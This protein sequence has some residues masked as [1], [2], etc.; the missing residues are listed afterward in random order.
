MR[1][2]TKCPLLM[3]LITI[4]SSAMV[5]WLV[6]RNVTSY[7]TDR[8]NDQISLAIASYVRHL[9]DHYLQV[10]RIV[11]AMMEA[12]TQRDLLHVADDPAGTAAREQL[13]LEVIGRDVQTELASREGN[14]AFH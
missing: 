6:R 8:A 14:P 13:K 10:N 12:S 1:I 2:G 3:L 4:G 5:S 11:R 7:E 9:D